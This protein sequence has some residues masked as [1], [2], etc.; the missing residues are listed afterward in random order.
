[1]S[2]YIGNQWVTPTIVTQPTDID[3]E[4]LQVEEN[5]TYTAPSG[6]AY[7]PVTVNVPSISVPVS[8]T[9]G[10]TGATTV[11]EAKGNLE[12]ND[13]AVLENDPNIEEDIWSSVGNKAVV[14]KPGTDLYWN[15]SGSVAR[16]FPN[17]ALGSITSA[18]AGSAVASF[19]VDNSEVEDDGA[20]LD[21]TF[22]NPSIYSVY[23]GSSGEFYDK[24][25]SFLDMI[26]PVGSIYMSVNSTNPGTLFG[27]TWERIQDTFLLA[28]GTSYTAGTTGGEATHTLTIDEMPSHG[29]NIAGFAGV[30]AKSSSGYVFDFNGPGYWTN[31]YAISQGGSKAHNNMPPYLAVY[32]WK[33]TA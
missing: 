23:C 16:S 27:G 32:V 3:V 31:S 28:S 17:G 9:N 20:E 15:P 24:E 13:V 8:I 10:G 29:H 1:M 14:V 30:Q 25:Y 4:S 18:N 22:K 7:S 19:L 21:V 2:L 6:T 11:T 12:I 33:R 26:Y 5:G